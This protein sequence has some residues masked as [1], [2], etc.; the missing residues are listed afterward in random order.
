LGA[1]LARMPQNI[2]EG[3]QRAERRMLLQQDEQ[4][5]GRM[6]FAGRGE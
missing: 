4:I 1:L 5:E 3:R 2:E 6:A